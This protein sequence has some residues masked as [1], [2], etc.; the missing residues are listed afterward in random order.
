MPACKLCNVTLKNFDKCARCFICTKKAHTKC[1]KLDDENFKILNQFK[2]FKYVCDDCSVMEGCSK[3]DQIV[4]TVSKCVSLIEEQNTSRKAQQ[5]ITFNPDTA[6]LNTKILSY[7]EVTANTSSVML[8][9]KND[10]QPIS[11]TKKDLF[12]NVD[13][14]KTKVNITKVKASRNGSVIITC[15]N[16]DDINKIG[17]I[18]SNNL[19]NYSLKQLSS[20][21]PRIRI[22][23]IDSSVEKDAL[24]NYVL[25]QNKSLFPA[26]YV[27]N[28]KKFSTLRNNEALH[29]A[30]IE[31][32]AQ[33]YHNIIAA[34]KLL[35]GYEY[36]KVWDA[37]DIRRC[38]KCSG[39]NHI[40][41]HCTKDEPTCPKCCGNHLL[42]N[43]ESITLTCSN[44]FSRKDKYP[45]IDCS[46][47]ALDRG[48]ATYQSHLATFRAKIF[49][50]K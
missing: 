34:G 28:L 45:N 37:V 27:C 9:P 18:V 23:R 32:D 20:L 47:S 19:P 14:I 15:D 16:P 36:C 39:F 2:N 31:V 13:P 41:E 48:C 5:T 3:L 50:D 6:D 8:K 35:V 7:A 46:H 33:S 21:L 22:S 30:V 26:G 43:C 49:N 10:N 25:N 17:N 38:F 4:E 29:Q 42:K 12:T 40:S 1:L 24:L 11:V 44:C